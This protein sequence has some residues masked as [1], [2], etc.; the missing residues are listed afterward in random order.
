MIRKG[1]ADDQEW[2][3]VVSSNTDTYDNTAA[4]YLTNGQLQP[5]VTMAPKEWRRLDIVNAVGD[6]YLELETR[7]AADGG[8]DEAC[9]MKLLALDGVFLHSGPRPVKRVL[10]TPAG[11]ASVAVMCASAGTFYLQSNHL[12]EACDAEAGF[13]QVM[14][15]LKVSGGDASMAEPSWAA[16]AIARP[17]YLES[18]LKSKPVSSW[19][20]GVE[21]TDMVGGAAW[22]GVGEDC[23]R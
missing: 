5:H 8:G 9:E 4:V 22:L 14:L 12:G 19:Q 20:V 13:Q 11:R 6:V 21:Q 2:S 7:T 18:L 3:P 10:L 15:T 1:T 23:C 16:T 17:P